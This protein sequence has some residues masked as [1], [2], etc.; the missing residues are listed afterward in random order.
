MG[1]GTRYEDLQVPIGQQIGPV[2]PTSIEISLPMLKQPGWDSSPTKS[3]DVMEGARRD[4]FQS[5]VEKLW[6]YEDFEMGNMW[7]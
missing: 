4:Q 2:P 5:V 6:K 3:S 7:R 1:P